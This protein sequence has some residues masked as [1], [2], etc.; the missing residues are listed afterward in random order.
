MYYIATSSSLYNE[1]Q[2][3]IIYKLT[4]QRVHYYYNPTVLGDWSKCIQC[5]CWHFVKWVLMW[6]V[7][8]LQI[9]VCGFREYYTSAWVWFK[10]FIVGH[11]HHIYG[12]RSH[13]Q[14]T[15]HIG[16]GTLCMY[17]VNCIMC[18]HNKLVTFK[19][20]AFGTMPCAGP[21]LNTCEFALITDSLVLVLIPHT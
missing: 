14:W 21:I 6:L 11:L 15:D 13:N 5:T 2:W 12:E 20:L 17:T 18:L 7:E 1:K 19:K 3:Y 8:I 9:A 10:K 16:C 4:Q